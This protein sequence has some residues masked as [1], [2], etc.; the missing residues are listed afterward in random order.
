M[1]ALYGHHYVANHHQNEYEER[2]RVRKTYTHG[3]CHYDNIDLNPVRIDASNS[4]DF[5]LPIYE[6]GLED[7]KPS[8]RF[9]ILPN[10]NFLL[11]QRISS[12]NALSAI[13][14]ATAYWSQR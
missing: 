5:S 13:C 11:A 3:V 2:A 9:D 10:L 12:I 7:I 4:T 1:Y 6:L 14:E 8:C